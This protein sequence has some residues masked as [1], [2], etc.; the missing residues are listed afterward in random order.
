MATKLGLSVGETIGSGGDYGRQEKHMSQL[1]AAAS[2]QLWP[3][4]APCG[5][6]EGR[7][8]IFLFFEKVEVW[9]LYK[10]LPIFKC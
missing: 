7:R 9:I 6:G 1:K 10:N 2:A 3:L 8:P 4:V 5:S